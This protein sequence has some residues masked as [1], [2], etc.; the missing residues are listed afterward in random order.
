MMQP[1]PTRVLA[2]L[3]IGLAA[4][5]AAA[6]SLLVQYGEVVH[7]SGE[8]V[9]GMPGVTVE[10]SSATSIP[11]MDLDGNILWRAKL[12]GAGITANVNDQAL[13]YGRNRDDMV[14][15]LQRGAPEPSGSLGAGVTVTF[16]S[17][18]DSPRVSAQGNFVLFGTT[19]AGTG[20]TTANDTCVFMGPAGA[21]L[22]LIRE[23][24][25]A[26]LPLVGATFT[27]AMG[28][29]QNVTALNSSGIAVVKA[30]VTGGGVT[31]GLDDDGWLWGQPGS[32]QWM[33]R[34]NDLLP[35]GVV[36]VGPTLD[37]FEPQIDESGRV[38]FPQSLSTATGSTPA[39]TANDSTLMLYTPGSGL[40]IVVREGDPAPGSGGCVYGSWSSGSGWSDS[41]FSR[42]N[43]H[44]VWAN[45]M[46]AGDVSGSTNDTAVFAGQIGG[47]FT[48]IARESEAAPT[49]VPG[50]IYQ[51]FFPSGKYQIND[52]GTVV[53]TAQLGPTGMDVHSDVAIFLAKP[54]YTNPGDVQMIVREGQ[55]VAGL[56]AGWIIDNTSG[57]GMA[58]S[59]TTVM[60]NEQDT[61]LISV[62]GVGDNTQA[63]WGV[64][65]LISWNKE[66]G[67]RSVYVQG[68]TF[69]VGGNPFVTSSAPGIVATHAGDGGNLGF[70][71]NGDFC[72]KLFFGG[73]NAVVRGHTGT[74]ISEPA[75]VPIAGG[76]PQNFHIDCGPANGGLLYLVLATSAGSRPGFP[77]P[78]G[79]QNV[80]LNFDPLW[81]MI[82]LNNANTPLWVNTLGFTDAQGKGIG[83][84]SFVMPPGF[85]MFLNTTLHH[86]ALVFDGSLTSYHVTEASA[87]SFY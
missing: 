8:P 62:A 37:G 79:P 46:T 29:A 69:T 68:D 36:A 43:G 2:T 24:D 17:G 1:S 59:S 6:Q 52:K 35:G 66:N 83:P 16:V 60:L 80:P 38:L 67:A 11:V 4:T 21:P 58:S 33:C 42:L 63:N 86:A 22:V 57:G 45:S 81:T 12:A 70:N 19:L 23:G 87:L 54:P 13:F 64:P 44:V 65:A 31:V 3:L 14:M 72:V 9:I 82:S 5:S 61:V 47:S 53:F 56:P 39:T 41:G 49:G 10:L 76:V 78:F 30:K 75:S 73:Q 26:P 7:G 84:S 20:I 32:L 71:N 15:L 74:M 50:E 85:P 18:W 34:E 28:G 77:S 51:A 25:S 55:A 27:G 40:S 48:R